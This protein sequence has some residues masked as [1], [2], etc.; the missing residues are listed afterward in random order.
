MAAKKAHALTG[1]PLLVFAD[2]WGRHPSSCQHLIR[3]LLDRPP[4]LWVNTI[5]TRKP[6]LD[7]DTLR[8]GLEKLRHWTRRPSHKAAT[9]PANL[10]VLNPRMWPSFDSRLAR[11]LNCRLLVPALGTAARELGD[12]PVAITTIPLV[13]DLV[14]KLPVR[15]WVYYCVDDFSTWPGLDGG[16]LRSMEEELVKRA[17]V[18]IA[19]SETL[20]DRLAGMGR[21]SHLLTHGVDTDFWAAPP[22]SVTV[23]CLEGRER[24]LLV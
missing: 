5:G 13:A 2:D 9:L 15:R 3:R 14:G 18:V 16:T 6:R 17:D 10:R 12:P 11:E 21:Q 22:A 23:S 24:P 1:L 19:V 4:T 20:Q 8:R 7:L